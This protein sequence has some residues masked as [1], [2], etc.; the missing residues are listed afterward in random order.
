MVSRRRVAWCDTL[1]QTGILDAAI[2]LENLLVNAPASDT[3]TV[4]RIIGDFT[5]EV[6]ALS[7]VEIGSSVDVGIGVINT[8]AFDLG[9]GVGIPN[10]TVEDSTPPR[11]WL[12]A[13]RHTVK[14]SLPTGGTPTAMWRERAHFQFDLRGQRKIDKGVLYMWVEQNAFEGTGMSLSVVGRIRT[15]FKT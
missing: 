1:L 9:T 4:T 2:L 13:M 12:Y 10:P 14:Q 6:P 3:M 11:G 8:E 15:L 7:E 5:V